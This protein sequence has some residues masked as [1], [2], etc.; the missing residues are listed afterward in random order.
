MS[1]VINWVRFIQTKK[2]YGYYEINYKDVDKIDF[3][4]GFNE[5]LQGDENEYVHLFFDVDDIKTREQYN[6]LIEWFN[7]IKPI[8]GEYTIGGYTSDKTMF[9]E[10]KKLDNV[11]K[12][13]SFH[14]VYYETKIKSTVLWELFKRSNGAFIY[15]NIPAIIDPSVYG[16]KSRRTLR[17]V[18]S[19][20]AYNNYT[21][22]KKAGAFIGKVELKNTFVT[23]RGDEKEV[24]YDK[25]KDFFGLDIDDIDDDYDD[26]NYYCHQHKLT[27]YDLESIDDDNDNRDVEQKKRLRDEMRDIIDKET[28]GYADPFQVILPIEVIREI[29]FRHHVSA[30]LMDNLFNKG[31]PYYK[32]RCYLLLNC[33]YTKGEMKTLFYEWHNQNH[34]PHSKPWAAYDFVDIMYKENYDTNDYYNGFIKCLKPPSFIEQL[35]IIIKDNADEEERKHMLEL[36]EYFNNLPERKKIMKAKTEEAKTEEAKKEEEAKKITEM[37]EY[38]TKKLIKKSNSSLSNKQRKFKDECNELYNTYYG[39]YYSEFGEQLTLYNGYKNI[40]NKY[41][42]ACNDD[43]IIK[44]QYQNFLDTV[45]KKLLTISKDLETNPVSDKDLE[46]YYRFKV[47]TND[48]I[49]TNIEEIKHIRLYQKTAII[50][51]SATIDS[52]KS[53]ERF[54]ELFKR[55]FANEMDYNLYIDFVRFKLLN[56]MKK[57]KYNIACYGGTGIFKTK[58]IACLKERI[59]VKLLK[60]E[61]LTNEFNEWTQDTHIAMIDEVPDNVKQAETVRSSVKRYSDEVIDFRMKHKPN[62]RDTAI[63]FNLVINSNHKNFG[64][65]FDNQSLY[66]MFRRFHIIERLDLTDDEKKEAGKLL[67]N[68]II[69]DSVF[70]L[71]KA[72]PEMTDDDIDKARE[73]QKE[74]YDYVKNN[75]TT[76]GA[77]L[78][79]TLRKTI[80]FEEGKKGWWVRLRKL[81]EALKD[82]NIITTTE[83]EKQIL[84]NNN[85][86]EIPSKGHYRI[87]DLKEYYKLYAISE[88]PE[89]DDDI[90]DEV[91]KLIN[92]PQ[93]EPDEYFTF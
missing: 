77:L 49:K 31:D 93:N 1:G 61:D 33:P 65:L 82:R 71:I 58:F 85:I 48:L 86:V 66:E 74:Y 64:G 16:Y 92:N 25:I 70:Y 80:T 79:P 36:L 8:F 72:M 56:P 50:G 9:P 57:Y 60:I 39:I 19:Y 89:D 51:R 14:V 73:T 4:K 47:D 27:F 34:N 81:V 17:H 6:E 68:D 42:L 35:P 2:E 62:N 24:D 52:I 10:F 54:L 29:L 13:V 55:S 59:N 28:P 43:R 84:L 15:K 53:A 78:L 21:I 76:R 30:G 18:L 7:S 45:S 91:K 32:S 20:K 11:N 40:L 46:K 63:R 67:Y 87:I 12:L 75:K 26:D 23:I 41:I 88:T 37:I 5:L 38:Y 3:K 90:E 69:A 44:P 83:N 22:E